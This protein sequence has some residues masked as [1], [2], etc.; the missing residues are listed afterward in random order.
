MGQAVCENVL[1]HLNEGTARAREGYVR[2][3]MGV[4]WAVQTMFNDGLND[5]YVCLSW[6]FEEVVEWGKFD[7]GSL[8]EGDCSLV[9]MRER[10]PLVLL[11]FEGSWLGLVSEPGDD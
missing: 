1:Y 4:V 2:Y 6:T 11:E 5:L 9:D 3:K 8:I 7:V 10:G